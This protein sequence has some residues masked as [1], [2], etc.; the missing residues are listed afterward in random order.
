MSQFNVPYISI[1]CYL[2]YPYILFLF[3]FIGLFSPAVSCPQHTHACAQT[4]GYKPYVCVLV[5]Q[6]CPTL[7]NPMDYSPP[8]SSVHGI[9]QAKILEWVAISFSNKPHEARDF[10]SRHF[11][12]VPRNV[13]I[14]YQTFNKYRL[15]K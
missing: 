13:P 15:N 9:L 12:Q 7:C 2:L 6:S 4:L 11:S 8:G 1:L 5:A 10:C 14:T 3:I